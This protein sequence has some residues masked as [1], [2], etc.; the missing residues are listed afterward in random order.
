TDADHVSR[1]G[2]PRL[3]EDGRTAFYDVVLDLD[4]YSSEA[5]DTIDPLRDT[6]RAAAEDAGVEDATV[7]IGGETAQMAD[8]RSTLDR[9]TTFIV[10]LVLVLVTAILI[11]LLRSLLAPL[12]LM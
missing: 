1:V 8:I 7:V 4:P 10:P 12:Y 11:F 5:L 9:D 3:G 2:K 6:A